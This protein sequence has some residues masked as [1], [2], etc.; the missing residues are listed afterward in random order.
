MKIRQVQHLNRLPTP[1]RLS[2]LLR[3]RLREFGFDGL[4]SGIIAGALAKIRADVF[5][6]ESRY[7]SI[8]EDLCPRSAGPV[9]AIRELAT[10]VCA[11]HELVT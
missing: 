4:Y 10:A 9:G 3:L 6:I 8:R 2:R 5:S 11:E 7:I 1:T